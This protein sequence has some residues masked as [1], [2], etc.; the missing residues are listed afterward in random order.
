[1]CHKAAKKSISKYNNRKNLPT[2]LTSV[3]HLKKSRRSRRP[4]PDW[5]VENISNVVLK[6][7]LPPAKAPIF[8]DTDKDS[9]NR[10]SEL[11]ASFSSDLGRLIETHRH[12]TLNYGSEFRPLNDMRNILGKHP[13]FAFFE[14]MHRNRMDYSFTASYVTYPKR[15]GSPNWKQ[16]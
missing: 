3:F 2:Q 5:L 16:T 12:T 8:F 15:R 1:M 6:E 11:L 13:H 4:S 14:K 9:L 10:N 7:S